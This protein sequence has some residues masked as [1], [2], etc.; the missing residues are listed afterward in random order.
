MEKAKPEG[1]SSS[2]YSRSILACYTSA[3]TILERVQ[4]LYE[5]EPIVIMRFSFFWTHSFSSAVVL[6]AIVMR[7]PESSFTPMAL[8]ELGV[9]LFQAK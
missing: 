5:Q 2:R 8:L 1:S 3:C 9:Y 6:S 7:S 4:A